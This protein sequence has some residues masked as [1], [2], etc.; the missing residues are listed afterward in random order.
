MRKARSEEVSGLFHNCY[1][2]RHAMYHFLNSLFSYLM[3]SIDTSWEKFCEALDKAPTFD[4]ILKIHREFQQEIL[5]TTFNTPRGKQ[6][7]IALNNIYAV[8]T[9]FKAVSLRL[10]ENFEEYYEKWRLYE[11]RQGMARKGFISS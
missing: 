10:Q 8:I 3:V 4:H 9:N 7:L 6:L 11:D 5:D 2:L 1:L